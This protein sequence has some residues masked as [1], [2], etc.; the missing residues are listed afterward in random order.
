[1]EHAKLCLA[2]LVRLILGPSAI[3]EKKL[4]HGTKLVILGI[5]VDVSDQGFRRT[6][7]PE[8]VEK[9]LSEIENAL[10]SKK[11]AA[12]AASKLS[13]KLSWGCTH[14]FDKIG[15]AALRPLFDQ[16]TRRDGA[17]SAE[18]LESLRWWRAIL[19]SGVTQN[20]RWQEAQGAVVHL[21]CDAS[22]EPAQLGAVL[23]I[24]QKCCF[25]HMRVPH[26]I[27]HCFMRRR[28]KQI[29]ALE[30]LAISLGF[31]TFE[32]RLRH[33]KVVVHCDNRGSEVCMHA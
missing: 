25:T 1:M 6:P 3:A 9:W 7:A 23:F 21:F 19:K 5:E 8:K 15:R 14:M 33:R 12:G 4:E 29:M 31:C 17:M 22:G 24:D 13:G 10:S 11:L 27:L 16:T 2:R 28:D 18:L 30:L 32:N 20:K 26:E